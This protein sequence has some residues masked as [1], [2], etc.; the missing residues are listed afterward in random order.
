MFLTGSQSKLLRKE[1]HNGSFFLLFL[2]T[3]FHDGSFSVSG[4]PG[5]SDPLFGQTL[6]CILL[7]RYFV[8]AIKFYNQLI[9]SKRLPQIMWMGFRTKIELFQ[10]RRNFALRLSQRNPAWVS[11][12]PPAQKIS[13]SQ[14][15]T[16]IWPNTL[17]Q[18]HICIY[19]SYWFSLQRILTK[20]CQVRCG[21]DKWKGESIWKDSVLRLLYTCI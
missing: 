3:Y 6:V 21:W 15:P 13:D 4:W 16:I 11:S 2:K 7:W 18:I 19:L 17:Q 1:N 5:F 8:G 12:L 10:R 14:A 9:W 20:S